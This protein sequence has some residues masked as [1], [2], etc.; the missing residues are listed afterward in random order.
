M[1][2]RIL[3][4]AICLA[5]QG[6]GGAGPTATISGRVTLDGKPVVGANVRLVPTSE[7]NLGTLVATT[8]ADG[9]FAISR[10]AAGGSARPG[11]YDVTIEKS[12]EVPATDGGMTTAKDELPEITREL[13]KKGL[14]VEIAPGTNDLAPFAFGKN[15]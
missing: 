12:S 3:L 4:P 10:D 2:T 5:A 14:S 8:D 9:K 11:K 13:Q 7:V 1:F 15:R 6:C